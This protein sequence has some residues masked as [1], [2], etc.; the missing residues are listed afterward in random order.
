MR[1][2]LPAVTLCV[3]A[4]FFVVIT[5]C[6]AAAQKKAPEPMI[7]LL[8]G[9]KLAPVPFSHTTHV[10]KIKLDCI[11][12]HHKDKNPKEPDKCVTCHLLK[13]VKE[14]APPAKDA[15]HKNC[16]TCHKESAA[17]GIKAPVK[18]AEC[19]KKQAGAN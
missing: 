3:A 5:I 9:A 14:G 1:R 11:A 12:C 6:T 13:E 17:K 4:V 15:F 7:L 2:S 10:E 18:C 16:Q 19:H 8:E